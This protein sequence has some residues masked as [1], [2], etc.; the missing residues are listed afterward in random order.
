MKDF[1]QK[2]MRKIERRESRRR[3]FQIRH[4]RTRRPGVLERLYLVVAGWLDGVHRIVR[5][6]PDGTWS[7]PLLRRE[8]DA[9]KEYSS[10]VWG[11]E[12][13]RMKK[14]HAEARR[15]LADIAKEEHKKKELEALR[16]SYDESYFCSRRHG[17]ER[18][19]EEQVRARR[20]REAASRTEALL[21]EL[22][23]A[24]T[25]LVQYSQEL[26]WLH[27]VISGAETEP[28]MICT[29]ALDHTNQRIDIYWRAVLYRHPERERM[30]AVP[31]LLHE[32]DAEQI[33]TEANRALRTL[34]RETV[35]RYVQT[36]NTSIME[37]A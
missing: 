32:T 20:G 14:Y 26:S 11:V 18:L 4:G 17:E 13:T 12:Q 3:R 16:A 30:P 10:K 19:T 28:K 22:N 15:L 1:E 25:L 24:E 6:C 21:T 7:S 35:D 29:R 36:D 5:A 33:S 37:V 9:L 23:D 2:K 34:M 31:Q 27:S 8:E